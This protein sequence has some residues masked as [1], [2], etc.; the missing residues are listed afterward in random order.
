VLSGARNYGLFSKNDEPRFIR[1][2][3]DFNQVNELA[4]II[5]SVKENREFQP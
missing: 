1:A 4:S 2:A 3:F 5:P